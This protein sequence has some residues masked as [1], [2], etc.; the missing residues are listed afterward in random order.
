[1]QRQPPPCPCQ[2]L[3]LLDTLFFWMS[4]L[5]CFYSA[6]NFRSRGR[7]EWR[8]RGSGGNVPPISCRC[9]CSWSCPAL[10]ILQRYSKAV[11]CRSDLCR[12]KVPFLRIFV[13]NWERLRCQRFYWCR[14]ICPGGSELSPCRCCLFCNKSPCFCWV[15]PNSRNNYSFP[16]FIHSI[17]INERLKRYCFWYPKAA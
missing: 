10:W 5:P 9:R 15:I 3:P 6:R 14:L 16:G 11:C 7:R 13:F 2:L 1:M 12:C 4:V 17:N 8:G